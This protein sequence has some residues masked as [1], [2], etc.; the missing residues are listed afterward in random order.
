MTIAQKSLAILAT[1]A[2][3]VAI[4]ASLF[5]TI[6]TAEAATLTGSQIQAIVSLLQSFGA[7]PV[8]IANVSASLNGTAPSGPA[9]SGPCTFTTDLTIGSKGDAVTCLQ[10]ALIAAGHAIPAGAT[11]YFGSQT[12]SAVAAWQKAAGVS[13]AAGYFGAKS[14]AA[15]GGT[16][17][18]TPGPT[19]VPAGTGLTVAAGTQPINSLAPQGTSRVP[20][21]RI[22]LTA[23]ND[24]DVTVNGVTIQRTG[25]AADADFAGVI[26]VDET[27]GNQLGTAKTF[28]SNHQ[29]TVGGTFVVPKGTTRSYLVAGNMAASLSSHAG[30]APSL[31]VIAINTSAN[32]T[33]SLPI[34]GASQTTN[35]SLTTGTITVATSNANA[36]NANNSAVNLGSTA[37]RTTGLRLTAGS[38]EDLTLKWVN[39]NQTGS[40]SATDLADVAVVINGT[41]Y[42]LTVSSDG[43]YYAASLGSGIVI[44][45][46]NQIEI[47]IVYNVVGANSTNRTVVFDVDKTT[48]ILAYGNLYG[49]GVTPSAGTASVPSSRGTITLTSG[50]PYVYATQ[51]T[52]T[53]ASITQI[54]K[55]TEIPAQNVAVNVSNQPLGGFV[56]D[57]KGEDITVASLVFNI[58][59]SSSQAI[60]VMSAYLPTSVSLVDENGAVVA[61]PV[62]STAFAAAGSTGSNMATLTFTDTVTFH[63]GRHIFSLRGKLNSSTPNNTPLIA[64]TSPASGWTTVKGLTTG[65]T[66]SLSSNTSFLMN[67][68]TVKAGAL[69]IGPA[70]SP[71][72]QTIVPGGSQVLLANFQFDASQSGEDE[73]LSTIPA[74]LTYATGAV[75]ELT[76]CQIYDGS[77]SLTTGGHTVNPSG[78]SPSDN[79]F[80]LDNPLTITKGTVK[81]VG[82]RCNISGSATNAG[83]WTWTPGAAAF[84]TSFTVTGANSGTSATL[85]AGSGSG[86][87][88]TIGTASIT[89]A[90]DASSPGYAIVSAG[91]TG[92]TAG[93][94]KFRAANEDVTL[95]KLGLSLTNT[96]SSTAGDIVKASIYDGATKLGEAYFLS[97][98]TVATSTFATPVTLT[99]NTDKTLTVKVDLANVSLSDAA[100]SS[101]HLLAI[102][103]LNSEGS[104]LQ[105]G[106]TIQTGSGAGS[107]AVAGVRIMK[108]LPT[109][110]ADNSGLGSTGIA[111]GRLMRFKVTAD[112]GGPIGLAEFNFKFATTTATLSNVNIY[113]YTDANYSQ[114]ISGVQTAGMIGTT[115]GLGTNWVSLSTVIEFTAFNGTASTTVQV[116][117]GQSRYFEVRGSVA[118]SA[119]GASITTT[120]MGNTA[121]VTGGASVNS[122]NPLVVAPAAAAAGGATTLGTDFVWSPN[123]TTTAARADNDWTGGYGVSGLP[124]N[125]LINTR[126]N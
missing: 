30:E 25:V 75:S 106:T 72:S 107:T 125:G 42:P 26:L 109:I 62:D 97:G 49:Y 65:N 121:F 52:I 57:I 27:T 111:D 70:T 78:S 82:L 48:D 73:R 2:V 34:V 58:A 66:I 15:W 40:V 10:H 24:G 67:T 20:F 90:T 41:S 39:F 112:A 19:P 44:P 77:I 87:T 6:A 36:A 29:G 124:S 105:S 53:G 32:V 17:T 50:T 5:G 61:G 116:P 118:G 4:V 120:L 104:G 46:G 102:D 117:A 74:R 88:F 69:T 91:T 86:P 81:T 7:D 63:S 9:M 55:A 126:S 51:D 123:S 16:S 38:A 18:T 76:A 89:V 23:G 13:P 93:T 60:G 68:M 99:K 122:V 100:T 35:A 83:T 45:K 33:G 114:P 22:W 94:Y 103:Y 98:A 71:A 84:T 92:V 43:K 47:Y 101:G 31:S 110:A 113:G 56:A 119:S 54:G 64:S 11:G 3:S 79:T 115:N 1:A 21:T 14:R 59:T 108:S 95:T 37:N 28:N 85:T 80:T 12:Q 8:T 96:A